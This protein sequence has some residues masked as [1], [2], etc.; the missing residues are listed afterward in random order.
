ML[1]DTAVPLVPAVELA[2]GDVEPLDES[3][4]TDLSLFRPAPDEI[5]DLVPRIVRNPDPGQSSLTLF[6]GPHAPPLVRPTPHP[7]SGSSSPDTRF[8][9]VLADG[10]VGLSVGKPRLRSRRTPSASG[11]TPFWSPS[12][13]HRPE[14]G[15]PSTKCRLRMATFSSGV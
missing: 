10:W 3:P 9:P 13:S 6:L 11:R 14:I 8:V 2:G 12:S 5:H 1:I 4:G 7:S 15:I